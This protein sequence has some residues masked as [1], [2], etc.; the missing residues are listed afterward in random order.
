MAKTTPRPDGPR[1]L[2]PKGRGPP[3]NPLLRLAPPTASATAPGPSP[4]PTRAFPDGTR[5]FARSNP[6]LPGRH[7]AL[8]PSQPR[9]PTPEPASPPPPLP[10][11][12]PRPPDP[13]RLNGTS[14]MF[15]KTSIPKRA[16]IRP[17][18]PSPPPPTR[19][20]HAGRPDGQDR[21]R[22]LH[23]TPASSHGAPDRRFPDE[24][25]HHLRDNVGGYYSRRPD[26]WS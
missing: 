10:P 23:P 6:R 3:R 22:R 25:R 17:P 11:A 15:S 14:R 24:V 1:N 5:S 18:A 4:V 20:H 21:P 7:P 16:C 9:A 8:R 13:T 19:I 2:G 12:S 26:L